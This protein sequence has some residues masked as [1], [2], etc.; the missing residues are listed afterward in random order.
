MKFTRL[1]NAAVTIV[2]EYSIMYGGM[3][4]AFN[5]AISHLGK[6]RW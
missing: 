6:G 2:D 1:E 5:K 3:I 4:N